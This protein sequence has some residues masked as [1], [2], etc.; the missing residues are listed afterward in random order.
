V[1]GGFS[2]SLNR[3]FIYHSVNSVN[4]ISYYP[5]ITVNAYAV[6]RVFDV[7][8]VIPRVEYIHSRYANTEAT[9][10]LPAYFLAHLTVRA[11]IGERV[12]V[13]AGVE[14]IFDT[15]YEIKQYFPMAG[16]SFNFSLEVKY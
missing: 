14:N 15:L 13:S 7:V 16:R 10:E 2:F 8:S 3:Y 11:G 6:A 12:S 5:M 1:S 9:A 4:A